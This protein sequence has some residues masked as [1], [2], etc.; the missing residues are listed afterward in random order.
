MEPY[1]DKQWLYHHYVQKR[2]NLKD[3]QKVLKDNYNITV[4]VQALYNWVDRYELLR[5]RGKGRNLKK[6]TVGGKSTPKSPMQLRIEAIKREQR[7]RNQM[8]K[9]GQR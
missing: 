9:R 4:T 6:K 8:R 2:M 1:K 5:Y 3:I 7:K